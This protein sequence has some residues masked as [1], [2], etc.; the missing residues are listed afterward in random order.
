MLSDELPLFAQ[1]RPRRMLRPQY[2][3]GQWVPSS[4]SRSCKTKLIINDQMDSTA[5]TEMR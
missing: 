1:A 5:N 4:L 3:S 2:K